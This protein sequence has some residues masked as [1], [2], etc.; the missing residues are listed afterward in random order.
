MEM[1]L[2]SAS[3]ATMKTLCEMDFVPKRAMIS[4]ETIKHEIFLEDS[5]ESSFRSIQ[6]VPSLSDLSEENSLGKL[7]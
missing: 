3:D 6:K 7:F 5:C 1:K 4:L 2:R